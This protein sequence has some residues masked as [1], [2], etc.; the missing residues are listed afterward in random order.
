MPNDGTL[1]EEDVIWIWE[2]PSSYS[3]KAVTE[4]FAKERPDS[5]QPAHGT[6]GN[7]RRG[8]N[9]T[10]ITIPYETSKIQEV[11]ENAMRKLRTKLVAANRRQ[12][13]LDSVLEI[14]QKAE[15]DFD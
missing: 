4:A 11:V 1:S 6:V 12:E 2:Q 8:T 13:F 3:D 5:F 7:I 10:E 15:E 9:K 14:L